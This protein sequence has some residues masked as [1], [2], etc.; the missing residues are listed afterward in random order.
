MCVCARTRMC[1]HYIELP[2]FHYAVWCCM[3]LYTCMVLCATGYFTSR[4]A[5]KAYVREMN[6]L[7]QT[8]S[9][10][11]AMLSAFGGKPST[12][13]RKKLRESFLLLFSLVVVVVVILLLLSCNH[14]R[15]GTVRFCSAMIFIKK[16]TK[17]LCMYVCMYCSMYI[18]SL[19]CGK[20]YNE[21]AFKLRCTKETF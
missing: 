15:P 10:A 17:P 20:L 2:S 6:N 9:Q 5:L 8:C 19:Y 7:L 11:E 16:I 18:S 12:Y 13:S 21:F 1:I 4:P 3:Y 14:H